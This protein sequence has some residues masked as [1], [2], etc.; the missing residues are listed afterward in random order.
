MGLIL[1]STEKP[2]FK[3]E[4]AAKNKC[5]NAM[6]EQKKIALFIKVVLVWV[7]GGDNHIYEWGAQVKID[8][9]RW[10]SIYFK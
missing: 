5:L 3:Q 10:R 6:C 8:M 4:R 2:D 1:R 7:R 9:A